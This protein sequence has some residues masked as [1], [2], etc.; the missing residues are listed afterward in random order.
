MCHAACICSLLAVVGQSSD[1][2]SYL[3]ARLQGCNEQKRQN[4]FL[5]EDERYLTWSN[6]NDRRTECREGWQRDKMNID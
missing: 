6:F 5:R 2:L 4:V 3:E 1:S